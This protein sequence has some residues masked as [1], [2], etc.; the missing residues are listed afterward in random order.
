MFIS[1]LARTFAAPLRFQ[2][3]TSEENGKGEKSE[4]L[5]LLAPEF[6]RLG[7]AFYCGELIKK[8]LIYSDYVISR[9]TRFF[10]ILSFSS[11]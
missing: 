1:R 6:Y 4:K 2:S 11:L 7:V 3:L 10:F 5:V 8:G 9:L